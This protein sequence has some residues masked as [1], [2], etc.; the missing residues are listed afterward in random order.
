MGQ[1]KAT[2]EQLMEA[3]TG[4]TVAEAAA[5]VGIH[6]RRMWHHKARLARLGWSPE[7]NMHHRV[8]DGFHLKGASTLYKDGQPVLQ[9]VKSS[10][11]LER[12]KELLEAF[13]AG[14]LSESEPLPAIEPPSGELDTDII[15]WFQIG[16]AHVGMLAHSNE[17]GHNF[18]LKIA[19]RELT[20][21]M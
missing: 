7:H 20:M 19:E 21:A 16:D 15:P 18:D 8:P 12:Q 10:I 17:V 2:D 3:L 4:R 5:F 9:W 14:F 6:E 11:D 1:R 13:T